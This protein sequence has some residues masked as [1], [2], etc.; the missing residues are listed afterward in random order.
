MKT[1]IICAA[2]GLLLAFAGPAMA[3]K[4]A[5]PAKTDAKSTKG[6]TASKMTCQDFVTLEEVQK[7]KVVYWAEGLNKKGKVD[8]AVFDVEST[9]RLVPVLVESCKLTPTEPFVKK[10]KTESAKMESAKK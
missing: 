2:A 8:D 5:K 4:T 7:P 3:D 10:A 6:M 1:T 9:D